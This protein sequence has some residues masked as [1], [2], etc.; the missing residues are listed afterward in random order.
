MVLA[1]PEKVTDCEQIQ[2]LYRQTVKD[3]PPLRGLM[4]HFPG[5]KTLCS[6]CNCLVTASFGGIRFGRARKQTALE[7][8]S[9]L[10][11]VK[12]APRI[13]QPVR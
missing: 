3:T 11:V 2:H 10:S 13:L 7:C 12:K 4:T 9:G 1:W 6:I 8:H 5:L